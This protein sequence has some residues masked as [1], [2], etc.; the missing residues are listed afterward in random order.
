MIGTHEYAKKI[1]VSD[2]TVRRWCEKGY[3]KGA[4]RDGLG[5]PWRIPENAEPPAF[6]NKKRVA[7]QEK[8]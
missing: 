1:G 3:L 5:K 4:E 8:E 2:G 7:S 6:R